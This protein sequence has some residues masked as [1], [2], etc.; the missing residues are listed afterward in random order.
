LYMP[1]AVGSR[2]RELKDTLTY[3]NGLFFLVCFVCLKTRIAALAHDCKGEFKASR[4]ESWVQSGRRLME[5]ADDLATELLAVTLEKDVKEPS[6]TDE[7]VQ[8]IAALR[9]NGQYHLAML[10]LEQALRTWNLSL[11][12]LAKGVPAF[13]HNFTRENIGLLED[14]IYEAALCSWYTDYKQ[15]GLALSDLILLD[16]Q[17]TARAHRYIWRNVE[18]FTPIIANEQVWDVDIDLPLIKAGSEERYRPLNPAIVRDEDGYTLVVKTVNFDQIYGREYY[19]LDD[20]N[21][22]RVRNFLVKTNKNHERVW[23]HEIFEDLNRTRHGAHGLED[24][25]IARVNGSL[26]FTG[27]TRSFSEWGNSLTVVGRLGNKATDNGTIAVEEMVLME[28]RD[29]EIMEKNWLPFEME[30][31]LLLTY[32]VGPSMALLRPDTKTGGNTTLVWNPSS[33]D[34]NRFRGSAGPISFTYN[35]VEGSLYVVHE[36]VYKEWKDTTSRTYFHRFVFVDDEWFVTHLSRLFVFETIGVEFCT[37]MVE[38]HQP[39]KILVTVGIEDR[40]A[41]IYQF[42]S[43]AIADMLFEPSLLYPPQ[44]G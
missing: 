14:M 5:D 26:W 39:G 44:A 13:V 8:A 37:G 25:R 4:N 29:P 20:D 31:E 21:Y 22:V 34:L 18:Y 36:V 19:V 41:R 1:L 17:S 43:S 23:Q 28:V 12:E 15:F 6:V 16:P 9:R 10:L 27:F 40:K 35:G 32:S 30:G 11:R 3:L 42:S 38:S 33:F 2:W 24:L 7:F